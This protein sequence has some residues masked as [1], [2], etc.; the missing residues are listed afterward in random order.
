VPKKQYSFSNSSKIPTNG[1]PGKPE[2][3]ANPN[4]KKPLF[5]WKAIILNRKS[6]DFDLQRFS[7]HFRTQK[8]SDSHQKPENNIH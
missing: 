2:G 7:N 1:K 8:S 4:S 3:P 6:D 5:Y